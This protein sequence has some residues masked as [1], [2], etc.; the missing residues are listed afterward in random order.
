MGKTAGYI[1]QWHLSIVLN[2]GL[3]PKKA[4]R[5]V[6]SLRQTKWQTS[7]QMGERKWKKG[8]CFYASCYPEKWLH[9]QEGEQIKDTETITHTCGLFFSW[10]SMGSGDNDSPFTLEGVQLAK[11]DKGTGWSKRLCGTGFEC[12]NRGGFLFCLTMCGWMQKKNRSRLTF[13]KA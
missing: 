11:L 12:V 1:P 3:S 10:D 9:L 13:G 7:C 2:P 4:H 6:L 5:V 8:K